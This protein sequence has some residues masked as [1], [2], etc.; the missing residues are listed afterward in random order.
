MSRLVWVLTYLFLCSCISS[1]HAQEIIY[2]LSQDKVHPVSVVTSNG[3]E[4]PA[5]WEPSH[6]LLPA[7]EVRFSGAITAPTEI[8]LQQLDG[9]DSVTVKA[10]A[11]KGMEYT[12]S[13]KSDQPRD[14]I[15]VDKTTTTKTVHYPSSKTPYLLSRVVLDGLK[16]KIKTAFSTSPADGTYFG[17]LKIT[18]KFQFKTSPS[19]PLIARS[20][21][22][23]LHIKV[24]YSASKLV[25]ISGNGSLHIPLTYKDKS[26]RGSGEYTFRATGFFRAGAKL[27]LSLTDATKD[28]FLERSGSPP[29]INNRILYSVECKTCTSTEK[30]IIKNGQANFANSFYITSPRESGEITGRLII[31]IDQDY[32]TGTPPEDGLYSGVF[33]LL[34][35]LVGVI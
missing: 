16:D 22:S 6:N 11:I 26:F 27:H 12:L 24:R 20:V 7:V 4:A 19:G 13:D 10:V 25:S 28:Y 33:A 2:E 31:S 34:F 8:R 14:I 29:N 21:D 5:L 23:Y 15:F 1:L 35:S 30:F 32:G 18:N 17:L 3:G 9:Q